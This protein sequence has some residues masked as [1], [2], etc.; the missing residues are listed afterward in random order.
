MTD[1]SCEPTECP[2]CHEPNDPEFDCEL[3]GCK[4]CGKVI[5]EN[6]ASSAMCEKCDG[7]V[8]GTV[9]VRFR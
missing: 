8:N 2:N 3:F 9:T 5:C 4:R 7:K 1:A 6:C